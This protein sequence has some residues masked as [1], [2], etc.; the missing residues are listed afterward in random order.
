MALNTIP[1]N[2]P[3]LRWYRNRQT[4][5][6][7]RDPNK[8]ERFAVNGFPSTS[9][10]SAKAR[11]TGKAG[12]LCRFARLALDYRTARNLPARQVMYPLSEYRFHYRRPVYESQ[13]YAPANQPEGL[14]NTMQPCRSPNNRTEAGDAGRASLSRAWHESAQPLRRSIRGGRACHNQSPRIPR[15]IR[16]E[17]CRRSALLRS[18][19]DACGQDQDEDT[20]HAASSEE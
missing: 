16:Y 19:P 8:P 18:R 6:L 17:P 10:A 13:Q 7:R 5:P 11:G 9:L 1:G 2:C 15:R 14:Q 3:D 20:H 12:G 4:I